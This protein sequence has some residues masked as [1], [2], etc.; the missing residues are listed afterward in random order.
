M[1]SKELYENLS[2]QLE[3][4]V[5]FVAS[6]LVDDPEHYFEKYWTA[7]EWVET[8]TPL[9]T[10]AY[11]EFTVVFALL[12]LEEYDYE[13][14]QIEKIARKNSKI[15]AIIPVHPLPTNTESL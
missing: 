5:P 13:Q 7:N 6:T 14:A 3:T 2:R 4:R 10:D 8:A 11:W 1:I 15:H 9:K 12:L